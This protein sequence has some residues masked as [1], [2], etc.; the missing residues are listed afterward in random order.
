RPQNA[1]LLKLLRQVVFY[2]SQGQKLYLVRKA[3][4]ITVSEADVITS[5]EIDRMQI[6]EASKQNVS[7]IYPYFNINKMCRITENIWIRL[8]KKFV[9]EEICGMEHK[10]N[11]TFEKMKNSSKPPKA[12]PEWLLDN[13]QSSFEPLVN[14]TISVVKACC[15]PGGVKPKRGKAINWTEADCKVLLPLV[16]SLRNEETRKI[17]HEVLLSHWNDLIAS[18][19]MFSTPRSAAGF[20][21]KNRELE[22]RGNLTQGIATQPVAEEPQL[23]PQVHKEVGSVREAQLE[24]EMPPVEGTQPVLL[25]EMAPIEG[26]LIPNNVDA[27]QAEIFRAELEKAFKEAARIQKRAP[28]KLMWYNRMPQRYLEYIAISEVVR[29][30]LDM[31]TRNLFYPNRYVEGCPRWVKWF[32]GL[33]TKINNK[34]ETIKINQQ[35]SNPKVMLGWVVGNKEENQKTTNRQNIRI[36]AREAI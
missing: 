19:S 20:L 2:Y 12:L 27:A 22:R 17:D 8:D 4:Y 26:K 6:E 9:W 34:D 7:N 35:A 10:K 32:V 14:Q 23:E 28:L 24:A 16:T 15:G 3:N 31:K 18:T 21:A 25:V 36:W 29:G 5:D 1:Q 33:E 30:N 13:T 11:T